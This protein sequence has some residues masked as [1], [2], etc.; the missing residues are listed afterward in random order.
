M[1]SSKKLAQLDSVISFL[2]AS[3]NFTLVRFEKTPHTALE[4]LRKELRKSNAEMMVVKNT[5]LQKAVN[6]L[7]IEKETMHL[8]PLQKLAKSLKDNTAVISLGNDWSK[9]MNAFYTFAK[10]NTNVTF[11]FGSLDTN[12]YES[13]DLLKIAQLPSKEELVA[14]I[15]GSMKAPASRVTRALSYNMQ[16]FV[17][18]INAKAKQG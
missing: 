5:I 1:A 3:G 14:K 17:F 18:V 11:K 16:K 7:A 4:G 6:K 15:I 2:K 9:S 13:V 8:K 12:T 10:T